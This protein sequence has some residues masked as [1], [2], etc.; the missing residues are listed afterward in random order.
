MDEL[1]Q[2]DAELERLAIDQRGNPRA[3]PPLPAEF[4]IDAVYDEAASKEKGSPVYRDQEMIRIR[5]G[6]RDDRTRIVTD[7]DRR[8]YA[9][10]YL[11]WKKGQDAPGA[12]E[13]FPL[14][15][16]AMIP[17][18]AVVKMFAF[19]GIHTV[20]QLASASDSVVQS[21]GAFVGL[22]RHAQDWVETSKRTAPIAKLRDENAEL[23]SR[24]ETLE[25]MLREAT[26]SLKSARD[27]GGVLAGPDPQVESL[28]AQ[29]EALAAFVKQ[30]SVPVDAAPANGTAKRRGRPPGSK[31]KPKT[32]EEG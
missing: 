7:D 14:A 21:I 23:R 30:A 29:V 18:K 19:H 10:Q 15:Q 6:S 12:V 20:E 17:G 5:V 25:G 1:A 11:A 27:G 3:M 26:S 24:I 9:A 28:K 13:G 22:K 8:T 2:M 4:F 32:P 16:W 31:N